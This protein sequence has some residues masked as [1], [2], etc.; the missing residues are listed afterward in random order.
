M[1]HRKLAG[2]TASVLIAAAVLSGSVI[3]Q[4]IPSLPS[5]TTTANAAASARARIRVDINKNDGRKAS[6]SKNA[7]N[8]LLVDGTAPSY[9]TQGV[10]FKLSNGGS[11]G[12]N[13]RAVNNKK[14]QLQSLIY[15]RL[16]MDG[17]KIDNGDGGGV[18]KLEI[19]GLSDGAHSLRMWHSNVDGYTNSTLSVSVNGTKVMSGISCPTNVTDE[20]KAGQSFVTWNGSSVTILIT[21][22]GTSGAKQNVAWL[23]GFELDG[24]DCFKGV[25]NRYPKDCDR[26]V[27]AGAGLSWKAGSGAASHDVYIGT[28]Y[29]SVLNATKSSPEFKGNQEGTSY[30]LDSSF[31]SVPTYYW[32]VDEEGS[33]G[34]VKGSVYEF[35]VNRKSFPTAEGYGQYARGGRGGYVY[36]VT[37]LNDSG[38]GSLRYGL[39]TLTG[40]RTIVFDV[41]GTI[42]LKSVLCIPETGGDVYVAG[43]TAP[44]NGIAVENYTFGAMGS[45]DVVIRDIR[46]FCGDVSGKSMGGFG[47]SSC[48]NCIVDHCSI[49]WATDEGF[50]SRSAANLTFQWNIIGESLNNSVHYSAADRSDVERH[51]FAASISGFTG[52]FSHNLLI[53]NTGRNW[54][55]AGGMEQDGVTYGGQLVIADNV[56]YNWKDRTTDGGVRR[57]DFVNNYY[58]AGPVSNTSLHV[59]STDG[60][61]LNTG[62]MQKMYVSGNVMTKS[63]GSYILKSTDDA[64][65]SGKA[66]SGG[67]N[68]TVSDVKSNT[69][70][71]DHSNFTLESAD[72]AYSKVIVNAGANMPKFDKVDQR[73]QKEVKNGTY[74][75]KG[76]R[77]GLAGIIDSQTDAEGYPSSWFGTSTAAPTDTDRDGMPDTWENEHGLNANDA[78][79]GALITL[80]ADDYTNLEMYL[81]ELAGDPVQFNAIP[82]I[83]AFETIEAESF[84]SQSGVRTETG[85]TLSNV[86]FI[87]SG[88]S[89]TFA[90]VDFGD[91][92]KSFTAA[93]SGNPCTIGICL[94]GSPTPAATVEFD[95]TSGFTDYQERTFNIPKIS[96]KHSLTLTFTGGSGYLL[97]I[98][99]FVFSKTSAALN[100]KLIKGLSILDE[101]HAS[102]WGIGESAAE[103]SLVFGDRTVTFSSLPES[104]SGAEYIRTAC[105]SKNFLTG[106][107]AQFTANGDITVY[108]AL[109][110]RTAAPSWVSDAYTLTDEICTSS[111][112]VT[113][114][115]YKAD[116]ADGETVTLGANE[117]NSYCVNYDV[118]VTEKSAPVTTTTTE[119]AATTTTT[120]T[121]TTAAPTTTDDTE[122]HWGD[123]NHDYT[124][125][126]ADPT[127]IMQ[128]KAVPETFGPDSYGA[129]WGDVESNGDGI[130]AADA[131]LI[132]KA[133]ADPTI[134]LTPNK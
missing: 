50:S 36:H 91:G 62:D 129:K 23:N 19:S 94:D 65:S 104:V 11:V 51:A 123:A 113:F 121:T 96:G 58:K 5:V 35:N 120:T 112:D 71:F 67:K 130:T 95:G 73:Y 85:D 31:S 116:F 34:I 125:S 90:S 114:V 2:R 15:P 30:K 55:L 70:F 53:N 47:M 74:T 99:S 109:D 46:T 37:N 25:S 81:N 115:L 78:S 4:G 118:F 132:Q 63:D 16:T 89:I 101:E 42:S 40:A 72:T 111:N 18:L 60:N 52:T 110:S 21:P 56:V 7:E 82:A 119:A 26:H 27:D 88:D 122:L 9:T 106:T 28:D 39:E 128:C 20:D 100:G 131:L 64:W 86:G 48:N 117:Q 13:V 8:W 57:L 12:D 87:E 1:K 14:L 76:C 6:Y 29:D 44:G 24:A 103:G 61:E 38:E 49:H 79:D 124:V 59:V 68:S 41:G 134:D 127:F 80:S 83:S 17:A 84:S 66:V 75:Y 108:I 133:L 107:A 45:E 10:T 69:A 77:D 93:V 22:E 43:Q 33:N 98:D 54:S 97:N 126:V 32:R 92:A 102:S 105:D 3:T